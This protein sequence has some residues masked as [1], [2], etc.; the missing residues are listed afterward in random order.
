M[1]ASVVHVCTSSSNTECGWK[2]EELSGVF[3]LVQHPSLQL[4]YWE[5]L[6]YLYLHLLSNNKNLLCKANNSLECVI[7]IKVGLI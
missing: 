1:C 3:E 5:P 4:S 2:E 6:Q 7:E